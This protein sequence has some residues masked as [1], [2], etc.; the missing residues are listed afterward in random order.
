[1]KTSSR[2][3]LKK[4]RII[5]TDGD[6]LIAVKRTDLSIDSKEGRSLALA[7]NAVAAAD[8]EWDDDELQKAKEE[9][10]VDAED[11]GVMPVIAVEF[12]E[13]G[14]EVNS[15]NY[16]QPEKERLECPHCH[17]IDSKNH[18]KKVE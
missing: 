15:D 18:F 6:E 12:D 2:L 3:E 9:W 4:I 17:H 11:W 10:N 7:D 8:L 13:N 5:E 1:M 16:Q 14:E